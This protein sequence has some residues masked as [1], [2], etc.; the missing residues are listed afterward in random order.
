MSRI[1]V[2]PFYCEYP[3]YVTSIRLISAI[4]HDSGKIKIIA[5]KKIF[6]KSLIEVNIFIKS[7]Y[8]FSK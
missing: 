4:P 3:D 7:D 5:H 8:L 2:N 1:D 6:K